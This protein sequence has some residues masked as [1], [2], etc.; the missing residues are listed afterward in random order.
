M[1]DIG[2]FQGIWYNQG[3]APISM[4]KGGESM[5]IILDRFEGTQAVLE[6][7]N[8]KM[9]MAPAVLFEGAKEGDVISILV[10][11]AETQLRK[12]KIKELMNQVWVEE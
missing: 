8:R 7:P 1:D 4:G 5:K 10:D 11:P 3:D 2:S 12:E 6:L 9:V